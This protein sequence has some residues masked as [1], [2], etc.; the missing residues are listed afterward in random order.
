MQSSFVRACGTIRSLAVVVALCA[1]GASTHL[2]LAQAIFPERTVRFIVPSPPGTI[3]DLLPRMLSEK[4]SARWG[5]PV[6][7][8]NRSGAAQMIGAETVARAEPDGY[9][10][11]VTPPAP[12]VLEQWLDPKWA[13]QAPAFEPVTVLATFPQVLVVNPNV[14]ANTFQEWIAYAKANPGRMSYGS[15][16][17][18]STA[19]LAQQELMRALGIDLV[20]VPYQGMGPA[21]NDLIAGHIEAMFAAIGTALPYIDDGK[22]RPLALTGGHR[23]ARLPGLP[24]ISETFPGFDHIEWFA[25]VAPPQTPRAPVKAI[26]QAIAEALRSPDIQDRLQQQMLVSGGST[27]EETAAFLERER[28]RWHAIVEKRDQPK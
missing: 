12:L 25:V 3:I 27:P 10:L 28:Q 6:I 26:W 1:I 15:P 4:L 2:T 18:G 7:V 19:Q 21:I 17:V 22:L 20:H 24:A 11:L 9:T 14:P 23:L 16:G 5:H 8:E 13:S